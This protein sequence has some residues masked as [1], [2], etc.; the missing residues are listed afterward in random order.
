MLCEPCLTDTDLQLGQS[1]ASVPLS[2]CVGLCV[3]IDMAAAGEPPM[4]LRGIVTGYEAE[5]KALLVRLKIKDA[6]GNEGGHVCRAPRSDALLAVLPSGASGDAHAA[7]LPLPS[8]SELRR[9]V[10]QQPPLDGPVDEL[11]PANRDAPCQRIRQHRVVSDGL[12]M[13][14]YA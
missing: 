10:R 1:L 4:R 9:W 12:S 11:A 3:Q 2:L 5:T 13:Q 6:G 7:A 8:R 14:G